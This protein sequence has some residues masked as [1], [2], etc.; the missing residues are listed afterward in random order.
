MLE[1][2]L[3]AI[4]PFKPFAT[5][6]D[7]RGICATS[8]ISQA[9]CWGG[10]GA[11]GGGGWGGVRGGAWVL[12]RV[13]GRGGGGGPSPREPVLAARTCRESGD[14]DA[15][16]EKPPPRRVRAKPGRDAGETTGPL[17][18]G[19]CEVRS[20]TRRGRGAR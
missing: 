13:R 19:D 18:P 2:C 4:H 7:K 5:R 14:E 15:G 17:G 16:R 1:S 10:A 3:T 8:K 6:N 12:A 20:W 11:S 9:L